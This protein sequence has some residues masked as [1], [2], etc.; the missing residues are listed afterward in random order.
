MGNEQLKE[1]DFNV[2]FE[3]RRKKSK[4]E[5]RFQLI[6]FMLMI[7]LTILAFIAVGSNH[8][9][10]KFVIPFLLLL[11]SVQVGFQLYYFMHASEKGHT[12]PMTFM[13]SA[14]LVAFVTVLVFMTIIW[15]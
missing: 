15:W 11:A 12:F 14:I 7:F 6:S 1:P 13:Y 4:E 10:P 9:P 5:M 2:R 8:F 3:Y